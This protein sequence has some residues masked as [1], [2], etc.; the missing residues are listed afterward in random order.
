MNIGTLTLRG[1]RRLECVMRHSFA[2]FPLGNVM[3]L[4][5]LVSLFLAA[6]C[7]T[8]E[9]PD[10]SVGSDAQALDGQALDAVVTGDAGPMIDTALSADAPIAVDAFTSP[11]APA[12]IAVAGSYT[13]GFGMQIISN[14]RWELAGPGF[15]AGFAISRFD[16]AQG[17]ALAQNDATNMFSPLMWS[18]FEWFT[19]GTTLYMCQGP[20]DAATEAA[21]MSAPRASRTSPATTGCGGT[22]PW[23]VL[24]PL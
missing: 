10:A 22:F 11:D 3:S 1:R 13:D 7:P 24:T 23:S 20:F 15:M 5:C 6:G 21:A 16:N 2:G 19:V 8:T 14:A 17:F 18:R 4:G 12:S 9:M